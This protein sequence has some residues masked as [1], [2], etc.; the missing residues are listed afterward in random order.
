ML[1]IK[2][3]QLYLHFWGRLFDKITH[4]S[5]RLFGAKVH[6]SGRLSKFFTKKIQKI[7]QFHLIRGNRSP[8]FLYLCKTKISQNDGLQTIW[9]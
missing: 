3:L 9:R 8:I 2:R 1:I 7:I 5:G 6:F 4:F